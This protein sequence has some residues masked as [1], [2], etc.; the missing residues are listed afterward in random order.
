MSPPLYQKLT[1]DPARYNTG[2]YCHICGAFNN[3]ALTEVCLGRANLDCGV[4]FSPV[5][6]DC[7]L[8]PGTDDY[9]SD[10][11]QIS[12][13]E[14]AKTTHKKMG[15]IQPKPGN[16]AKGLLATDHGPGAERQHPKEIYWCVDKCWVEPRQT[17]LCTI[18][19]AEQLDDSALCT[20]LAD[21]YHSVRGWRA[22]YF[23]WKT[24]VS[25]EFVRVSCL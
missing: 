5:S 2:W 18:K 8:L 19:N 1:T 10:G 22:K 16:S 17:E 13:P 25:V 20:K 4:V 15:H 21:V 9:M 7:V 14:K 3:L 11:D 12:S 24:C 23:S 6:S